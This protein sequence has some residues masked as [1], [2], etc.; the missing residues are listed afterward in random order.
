MH[1]N[2]LV[3]KIKQKYLKVFLK[4]HKKLI[5]TILLI[6]LI[7]KI[8]VFQKV[9]V[10]MLVQILF[11]ILISLPESWKRFLAFLSFPMAIKFYLRKK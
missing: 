4:M 2:K 8:P 10:H 3:K 6:H 7:Q 11:M 1:R 5:I 9:L